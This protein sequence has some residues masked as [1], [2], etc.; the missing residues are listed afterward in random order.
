VQQEMQQE[1]KKARVYVDHQ[2]EFIAAD[3][4]CN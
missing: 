4:Q 2:Y 3:V 1:E